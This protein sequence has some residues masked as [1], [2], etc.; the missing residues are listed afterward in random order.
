[1]SGAEVMD[2]EI[3]YKG[4]SVERRLWAIHWLLMAVWIT[5][6]LSTLAIVLVLAGG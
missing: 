3:R 1:M 5:Q 6:L 2:D 4:W